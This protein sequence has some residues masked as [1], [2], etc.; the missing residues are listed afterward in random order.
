[1]SV[2]KIYVN[3]QLVDAYDVE[4]LKN[5]D[6][7]VFSKIFTLCNDTSFGE[8][9]GYKI[10]LGDPTETALISFAEK[11]NIDKEKYEKIYKRVE[12]VPFDSKRKMMTTINEVDGKY[13]V[14]TKGAIESVISNSKYILIDGSIKELT[15]EMKK[16]ILNENLNLAKSALRILAYAY[17]FEENRVTVYSEDDMKNIESNLIFVGMTGMIDPPRPEAKEAVSKC[18]EAGMIPVMITGDNIDTATA[19]AIELGILTNINQAIVG[20]EI[21]KMSDE[22]LLKKVEDIRVY[23]RVSPENK[24]RIVKAWKKSGKTVAMTGDGVNDAPALKGAD[25]GIG[26]GITRNRSIKKCFK[27][28]TC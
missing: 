19:I 22:E 25:I 2:R 15:N 3:N 6:I 28:D 11:I 18:F 7:D 26:M 14:C 1:M 12:E 24:I 4:N 21:D 8:E 5:I 16:A 23:A 17:K 20:I 9:N 10:M 13:M 27:Y